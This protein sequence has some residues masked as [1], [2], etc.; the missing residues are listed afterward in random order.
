MGYCNSYW[1]KFAA[2]CFGLVQLLSAAGCATSRAA[3]DT[4]NL[5]ANSLNEFKLNL[6]NFMKQ[7]DTLRAE[8]QSR[9]TDLEA[10]SNALKTESSQITDSWQ[11]LNDKTALSLYNVLTHK[12]AADISKQSIALLQLQTVDSAINT[13]INSQQFDTVVKELHVIGSNQ[14]FS[15]RVKAYITFGQAVGTAYKKDGDAAKN[16]VKAASDQ[17]QK[18]AETLKKSLPPVVHKTQTHSR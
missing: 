11:L 8:D 6:T 14:T 17:Q 18:Q 12:T 4:A 15:D 7:E 9:L 1:F 3:Q 16:N 10:E 5:S 13:Q 2:F